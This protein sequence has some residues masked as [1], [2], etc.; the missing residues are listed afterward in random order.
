[1]NNESPGHRC[2]ACNKEFANSR[3][4][5]NHVKAKHTEKICVFC[6]KEFQNDQQLKG[7]IEKC[8][9]Y[10][11]TTVQCDQCQKTLT[12]FGM[13]RHSESCKGTSEVWECPECGFRAKS[14]HEIKKHQAAKHDNDNV[15]ECPECGFRARSLHEIK[16]H[17]SEQHENV[18][19][20]RE[21]CKHWRNG[22]CFKGVRCLYSHVGF[23]KKQTSTSTPTPTTAKNWTTPCRHGD[24]CAWLKKGTCIF[25]HK[26]IGV[27]RP[28]HE[29]SHGGAQKLCKYNERCNRK[30][31]CPQKHSN[32]S[33]ENFQRRSQQAPRRVQNSGRLNH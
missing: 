33:Y 14:S 13:K 7:H 10:G 8:I 9:D 5:N 17:Q 15:C 27:Q 30:L 18:E 2:N 11:N 6:E 1:M 22:N 25:F 20:S 3:D 21:V 24:D 31:T 4:L 19:V 28:T 16:K 26:N 23:Q 32:P 12:R 29:K